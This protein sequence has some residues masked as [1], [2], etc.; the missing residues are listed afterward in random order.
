MYNDI[1]AE[2]LP[3]NGV[4]DLILR[5]RKRLSWVWICARKPTNPSSEELRQPHQNAGL[6]AL[7]CWLNPHDVSL[8][9]VQSSQHLL[10]A[11]GKRSKSPLIMKRAAEITHYNK[12][13]S[14]LGANGKP[15]V[16][17]TSCLIPIN[18]VPFVR[19]PEKSNAL[20]RRRLNEVAHKR[21]ENGQRFGGVV[22]S[23]DACTV[24]VAAGERAFVLTQFY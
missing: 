10:K 23:A 2:G 22:T 1:C 18:D 16:N 21:V 24:A 15:T 17:E 4:L 7:G 9:V 3:A 14:C 13:L 6:C 8:L 12:E 5:F 20:R 19:L 11:R